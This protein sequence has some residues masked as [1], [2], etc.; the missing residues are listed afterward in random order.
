M[1][2]T[3]NTESFASVACDWLIVPVPQS[4]EDSQHLADL[5]KA[6]DGVISSLRERG[7]LTG[8]LAETLTLPVAPGI[9]AERVLLVGLG[10]TTGLQIESFERAL[11]TAIRQVSTR[12]DQRVAVALP[13]GHTGPI[14]TADAVKIIASGLVVG[15]S[16]QGLYQAEPSRFPFAEAVIAAPG[17]AD[18]QDELEEA[19]E[20]G[21]I[22]GEAVNLT[23]ELV[24]RHPGEVY[25]ETFA[26]RCA[27]IASELH[28][29][30]DIFDE[31]RL[32][33]ER[34]HA[35][36]AVA[37]GSEKPPRVVVMKYKGG[38]A[39]APTI[40]LVGKGVTFDSGGLSLKPNDGMKSMKADM[41][42]AA[43]VLGAIYGIARLKL[44]V[45]VVAAVGLVENMPS[46]SSYKLGE[47]LQAR[48]GVTIE[49]LNTDAEGRL[50]LADVLSYIAEQDVDG[51]VDLATLTG[52]CV[53]ALGEEV[54]GAFTNDSQWCNSLLDA[55]QRAGEPIWQMPM[56]DS[57][58][59]QLKCDIADVRNVGTRWG[60]AVTAAKFLQRFV[61]DHPWVHLDIAGPAYAE[62][63]KPHREGGGTGA[64]VRTLI[65]LA[66][67]D[68]TF[69]EDLDD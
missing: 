68:D 5:D 10:D 36:L 57:F 40:A 4:S 45:N 63:T 54:T 13:C 35:L 58:D 61:G 50:V 18:E 11:L 15:S 16:G 66:G 22:I 43:T 12:K 33:L 47:V 31:P 25:P 52:A 56:F 1:Q 21:T 64:M 37:R 44:P 39:D 3:L 29:Q 69:E 42:G 30:C 60:G 24:N 23:R 7:D 41:A 51:I 2:I 19:A 32:K 67:K 27:Q 34:M 6:L 55:A 48:N 46:G 28:L 59:E 8:K 62:S 26:Q 53:V 9:A 20:Q 17:S 14:T 38:D 49:V 65:T